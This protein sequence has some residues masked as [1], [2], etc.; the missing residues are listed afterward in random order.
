MLPLGILRWRTIGWSG[1]IAVAVTA[2]CSIVFSIMRGTDK[3]IADLFVVGASAVFV[4]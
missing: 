2:A 3:E 4:L 1:R